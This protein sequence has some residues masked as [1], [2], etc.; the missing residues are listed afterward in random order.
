MAMILLEIWV[1][2]HALSQALLGVQV[3]TW[4]LPGRSGVGTSRSVLRAH[5]YPFSDDDVDFLEGV[6]GTN[7]FVMFVNLAPLLLQLSDT[8][9]SPRSLSLDS[10]GVLVSWYNFTGLGPWRRRI[11][12]ACCLFLSFFKFDSSLW[13]PRPLLLEILLH[14]LGPWRASI[15]LALINFVDLIQREVGLIWHR[16]NFVDAIMIVHAHVLW[17]GHSTCHVCRKVV[18]V[19][20]SQQIVQMGIA[21]VLKSC[22]QRIFLLDVHISALEWALE[23]LVIKGAHEEAVVLQIVNLLLVIGF[24]LL[25]RGQGFIYWS[26][27]LILFL[28]RLMVEEHV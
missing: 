19:M 22:W 20:P 24:E 27:C 28:V 15:H 5:A 21:G 9:P 23:L 12:L 26:G 14:T 16:S 13:R 3:L 18:I 25:S 6:L 2:I 8:Y 4:L 11:S 17:T 1:R 10:I 7:L